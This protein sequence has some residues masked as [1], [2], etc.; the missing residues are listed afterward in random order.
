[1]VADGQAVGAAHRQAGRRPLEGHRHGH[2]ADDVRPTS[3]DESV[4]T[5]YYSVSWTVTLQP[6]K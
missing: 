1:V 6:T 3:Y 4:Y 2:N 5:D